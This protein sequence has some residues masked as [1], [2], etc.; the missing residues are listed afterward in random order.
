M[1]LSREAQVLFS[2]KRFIIA[3]ILYLRGSLTMARLKEATGLT[4][5]DLDSNLRYLNRHGLVRMEKKITRRGPRT[6]VSMTERGVEAYRE[7]AAFLRS[8]INRDT[9]ESAG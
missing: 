6:L 7:L 4:W 8:H 1:E 2:H 3:T 9:G 5:G